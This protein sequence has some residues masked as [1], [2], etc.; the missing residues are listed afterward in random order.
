M[1]MPETIN[2]ADI[3]PLQPSGPQVVLLYTFAGAAGAVGGAPF[4]AMLAPEH[5]DPAVLDR[6]DALDAEAVR[7]RIEI[8]QDTTAL[9]LLDNSRGSEHPLSS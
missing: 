4:G 8:N 9:D 5:A 3:D 7:L 2:G 6:R 1:N